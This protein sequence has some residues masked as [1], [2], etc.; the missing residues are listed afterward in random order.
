MVVGGQ[1]DCRWVVCHHDHV[2]DKELLLPRIMR[3]DQSHISLAWEEVKIQTS[4][5]G[6][7]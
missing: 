3:M 7:Y 2:A 1:N 6:F 5:D 4:K